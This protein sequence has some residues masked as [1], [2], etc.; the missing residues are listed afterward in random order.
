MRFVRVILIT[1]FCFLFY[2]LAFFI[3]TSA[4][5]LLSARQM[6]SVESLTRTNPDVQAI[7]VLPYPIKFIDLAENRPVLHVITAVP[8]IK[9]ATIDILQ[10]MKNSKM[11]RT[12]K[13]KLG[14][15]PTPLQHTSD[16]LRVELINNFGGIY[17]DLDFVVLKNLS[18]L[19]QE[20]NFI[21]SPFE[22]RITNAVF[23]FKRNHS[24]LKEIMELVDRNYDPNVYGS[25][26]LSFTSSVKSYFNIEVDEAVKRG[27]VKDVRFYNKT[28]F[29]PVH[30]DNVS[31]FFDER[32]S[33]KVN[34][35]IGTSFAVHLWNK[36]SSP[37]KLQVD[38]KAPYAV[39]AREFCPSA[40]G[41]VEDYF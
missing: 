13:K 7:V 35:W 12:M 37:T 26:P 28:A 41:S 9:F 18:K 32:N 27:R 19:Y 16:F 5:G 30:Y 24:L 39:M 11:I 20:I 17:L 21:A 4:T 25:G 29:T 40:F 6:C 10:I 31:I 36:L 15:S 1:T 3:E 33:E 34:E 22:T 8:N 23:G 14:R 38:S 2:G